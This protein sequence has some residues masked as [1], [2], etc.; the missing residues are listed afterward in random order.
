M[1]F[2][3]DEEK[4]CM[5]NSR[6]I[7]LL[8]FA[9]SISGVAQGISMLAIP[10]Y[11]T[12]VIHSETLYG[13]VFFVATCIAMF[14]GVYAGTL[15][16]RYNRK[17]L[18]LIINLVGLA[19]I[20]SVTTLGFYNGGLPWQ[21]VAV[22]F[23]TTM[24]IYN[25]HFPNLYA[26]AQEITPKEEYAR[27]TSLLEIQGQLTFTLA[28]G[29]SAILLNGVNGHLN[30]FG[31]EVA[32]P[33]SFRA[34]KIWEVFAI[35]A[36]TYIVAFVIIY[37]IKSL[38][39]VA[40]HIDTSPLRERLQ[41]GIRFLKQKPLIFHFGNASLLVFLTILVFGLYV[42]PV[43]VDS[44]LKAGANVF[45]V[46]DM[47]FSLGALA[48]AF[49]T[50]RIFPEKK[51][52]RGIIILSAIAGLMYGVMLLSK[53]VLLFFAAQFVTGV[54]NAAVRIL[55]ITYL[56]HHIPNHLI[57]RANSVF[58]M[59]N[60]F[61]R[62]CLIGFFTLPFFHNGVQILYAVGILGIIC[63]AASVILQVYYQRL[64]DMPEKNS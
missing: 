55:R 9:N 14:W 49:V 62:V 27:I 60:V 59:L 41:T 22:V 1:I 16:D 39:V 48:A 23:A 13:K 46:G 2:G 33:F 3:N 58:F 57:G 10:W 28:G 25:I 15:I 52:V 7:N 12:G 32:M 54:C 50:T 17:K 26:Y 35:D 8:L 24:F 61:L 45:A 31:W 5:R 43:Y 56:F 4:R 40:R 51:A 42:M 53:M 21:A 37:R 63:V 18:F 6:A 11:F 34:L 36:C 38:P 29:F 44:Y 64:L 47:S 30:I 20:G 19:V